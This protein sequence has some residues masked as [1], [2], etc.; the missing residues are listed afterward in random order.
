M[1][2]VSPSLLMFVRQL[3]GT[4]PSSMCMQS[5]RHP[6]AC[7]AACLPN[8]I[9]RHRGSYVDDLRGERGALV[10]TAS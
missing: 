2:T 8:G 4:A 5:I 6:H 3:L 9:G 7:M 10:N 1:H